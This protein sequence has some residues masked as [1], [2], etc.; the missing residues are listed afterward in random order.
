MNL[1]KKYWGLI[2]VVVL[3]VIPLLDLLHPGLPITHDG[4]DHVARIANFY[5][6]L[7]Q[8]NLIPRWAGNLNWGYGHPILMF[9]YPL[10][11]YCASFFHFVGFSFV[12]SFKLVMAL[13]FI[14]SGVTMYLWVRKFLGEY[15]GILAGVLY[16]FAPYR[17]VDLYV[18]GDIGEH[19]AFLFPPL[20][21][22]FLLL[23]KKSKTTIQ[24]YSYGVLVG[25]SIAGLV[26]AHNAVS[27]MFLPFIFIYILYLFY[28]T[29]SIKNLIF[30]GFTILLGLLLSAFF[31]VPALFEGKYTLRD[32]VTGHG[33]YASRFVNIQSLIYGPW[34][35]GQ[36]GQ[37]TVQIGII[38]IAALLAFPFVLIYLYKKRTKQ[39]LL[40]ILVFLYLVV[41]IFVMLPVS[42]FIWMHI[43]L[44]QKFQFPWRFLGI[45]VFA[46][47]VLAAFFVSLFKERVQ[48]MIII[49]LIILTIFFTHTDWHAK[50]YQVKPTTF[51]TGIYSGTTDTGESSPIWSVRAME[52][53]PKA[54]LEVIS[55]AASI[56]IP[57][58]TFTDHRYVVIVS[59][60]TA[61][62][63]ENTLYFPGWNLFVDGHMTPFQ[64]QDPDNRGLMTFFVDKGKHTVEFI[65]S[66]TKVRMLSEWISLI[67]TGIAMV[68]F[69][70]LK[71]KRK[72]K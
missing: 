71:Y 53:R 50:G 70:A 15:A 20:I 48:K 25:L 2:I 35:Y 7:M 36:T 58:R 16:M 54:P 3:G 1:F 44:L 43:S 27:L 17:F 39:S 64:F 69:I 30:S 51:Y 22:Y 33:E 26:L 24:K 38:Q 42:Q 56:I 40:Y 37:F 9:L 32:I 55:G 23:L 41:G 11:S 19:V 4:Q 62:F 67:A 28:E 5:T 29:R 13:A 57:K 66:N 47:A 45:V 52:K 18:R 21:L 61:Q 10:P 59:S 46:T 65:F 34:N 8:G 6:S 49:V 63:R 12:D 60:D 72:Q 14:A 31:W 68:G